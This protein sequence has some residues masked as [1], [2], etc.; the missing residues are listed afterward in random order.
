MNY[1]KMTKKDLIKELENTQAKLSEQ[2]HLKDAL[3]KSEERCLQVKNALAKS[4]EKYRNIVDS[5]TIG[6]FTSNPNGDILFVNDAL[7]NMMEYSSIEEALTLNVNSLYQ[8]PDDRK[9]IINKLKAGKKINEHEVTLVTKTGEPKN[10]LVS[11]WESNN[12][13]SGTI[14]DITNLKKAQKELSNSEERFRLLAENIPGVIYLCK[15]DEL[16]TML[17]LNDKVEELT[18]YT[19]E[20]FLKNRVSFVDLYHPDDKNRNFSKC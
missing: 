8:N 2:N 14:L 6:F 19:K 11:A 7:V 1:S 18:G 13:I 17:Y 16:Y 10:L 9:Y 4:E 12:I 5:S 3:R 20:D 15:N